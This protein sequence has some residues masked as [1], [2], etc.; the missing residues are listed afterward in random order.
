METV[1]GVKS[2][3]KCSKCSLSAL[4]QAHNCF[5]TRLLPCRYITLF[6]VSQEIRCSG[7]CQV[8]TVVV[9]TTQ[10]VLSQFKNFYRINWVSKCCELLVKLCH[11]NRSPQGATLKF[12]QFNYFTFL[13]FVLFDSLEVRTP[14][15]LSQWLWHQESTINIGICIIIIIISEKTA[16]SASPNRS[17]RCM[18]S[19]IAWL[20]KYDGL[21]AETGNFSTFQN[22]LVSWKESFD[23]LHLQLG[24]VAKSAARG[25]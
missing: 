15:K 2:Y 13:C 6:Q 12:K 1:C 7:V 22:K 11:I 20:E 3:N 9:E 14:G 8:A 25:A 18:P 10:L 4:T 23:F 5:A 19:V 17:T 21:C 24:E 16:E